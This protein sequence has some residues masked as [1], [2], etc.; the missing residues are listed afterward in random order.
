VEIWQGSFSNSTDVGKTAETFQRAID[1]LIEKKTGPQLQQWTGRPNGYPAFFARI[2][3][4]N[5]SELHVV[6]RAVM[7]A[8]ARCLFYVQEV[9]MEGDPPEISVF[10][11]SKESITFKGGF[12]VSE[13]SEFIAN[14]SGFIEPKWTPEKLKENQ[15]KTYAVL[16]SSNERNLRSF[17][18]IAK[19]VRTEYS[20]GVMNHNFELAKRRFGVLPS[21][22]PAI[23]IVRG[24]D[25]RF[26]VLKKVVEGRDVKSFLESGQNQFFPIH[27]GGGGGDVSIGAIGKVLAAASLIAVFVVGYVYLNFRDSLFTIDKKD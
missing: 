26:S 11:S 27:G 8:P 17:G 4:G 22:L 9:D 2:S 6:K 5:Y 21:E 23:L 12:S 15:Q 10:L 18:K 3:A 14:Y 7:L 19:D 16:I 13:L 24:S 25:S 1:R 20:Y